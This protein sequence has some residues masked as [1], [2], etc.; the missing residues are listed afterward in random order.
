MEQVAKYTA[1]GRNWQVLGVMSLHFEPGNEFKMKIGNRNGQ[2]R[3]V[4]EGFA[5]GD[6]PHMV[7]RFLTIL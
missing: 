1:F 4:L 3:S 2:I 7:H 5:R 6:L